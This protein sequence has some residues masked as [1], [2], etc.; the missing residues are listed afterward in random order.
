MIEILRTPIIITGEPLSRANINLDYRL[1]NDPV[2]KIK[3]NQLRAKKFR[4]YQTHENKDRNINELYN[5]T[6]NNKIQ[7]QHY[8]LQ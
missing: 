8:R 1:K 5:V 2:H 6:K 4:W 7:T 3:T